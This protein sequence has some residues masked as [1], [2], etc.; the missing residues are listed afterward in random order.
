MA[1]QLAQQRHVVLCWQHRHPGA[2][3]KL[4]DGAKWC[5][6]AMGW[7]TAKHPRKTMRM[8]A[9]CD[10]AQDGWEILSM[11]EENK[12]VNVRVAVSASVFAEVNRQFETL[13]PCV[14]QVAAM[15]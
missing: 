12:R 8:C 11:E 15:I 9:R 3:E 6:I 5:G 1:G 2:A 4:Y 14:L 13:R 10:I 7:H